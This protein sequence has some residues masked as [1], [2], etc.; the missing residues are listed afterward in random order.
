ME[1]RIFFSAS[2]RPWGHRIKDFSWTGRLEPETGL[3]FDFELET[4][5]YRAEDPDGFREEQYEGEAETDWDAISVW[6]NYHA[7]SITSNTGFRVGSAEVPFCV[8]A[9]TKKEFHVDPLDGPEEEDPAF[10]IYLLGHDSVADHKIRFEATEDS[11]RFQIHW[12][13][14][15]ALT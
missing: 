9:L 3:W 12:T 15:I 6:D 10:S 14:R 7:C 13:A 8:E 1:D 11:K 5:K 4:E 2:P